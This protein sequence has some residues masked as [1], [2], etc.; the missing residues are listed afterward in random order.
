MPARSELARGPGPRTRTVRRS[1]SCLR[2]LSPLTTSP[3]R[4]LGTPL[5]KC[6]ITKQRLPSGK[7]IHSKPQTSSLTTSPDFL[8]RLTVMQSRAPL[9]PAP[10][11]AADSAVPPPAFLFPDG[12]EH[13]RFRAKGNGRGCYV[14]C[15]KDALEELGRNRHY[16]RI[17]PE[18]PFQFHSLLVSQ[19]GHQLRLRVIQELE[20]LCDR[21]QCLPQSAFTHPVLRRLSRREWSQFQ[22]TGTM[23]DL[24]KI[25]ALIVVPRVNRSSGQEYGLPPTCTTP[26]ATVVPVST[27]HCVPP[28]PDP[29]NPANVVPL[30]LPV[31]NGVSL[32]PSAGDRSNFREGLSRMLRIERKARRHDRK[33]ALNSFSDTDG[34][35]Q[36]DKASY[37]YALYSDEHTSKMVDVV[38]LAIALWRVRLWEGGAWSDSGSEGSSSEQS[39]GSLPTDNPA[40]PQ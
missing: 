22:E 34:G 15:W 36:N 13:P 8:I 26:S 7:S 17:N 37:T 24:P 29:V 4:M 16:K 27:I 2:P 25:I 23:K 3:V 6:M 21:L 32:F 1:R 20:L 11:S 39:F 10:S 28:V 30:Q 38:P 40:D 35:G 9:K 33:S 14:L 19:V 31:Y 12:I 5:R 18:A